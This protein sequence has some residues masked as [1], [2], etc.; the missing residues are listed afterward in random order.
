[1]SFPAFKLLLT[2]VHSDDT[3]RV[4]LAHGV[5][6]LEKDIAKAIIAELADVPIGL[7]TSRAKVERAVYTAVDQ[8]VKKLK[9]DTKHALQT[10]YAPNRD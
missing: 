5:Q 6:P 10:R 3:Q 4:A 1:M 2:I 8:L 9:D 7:F